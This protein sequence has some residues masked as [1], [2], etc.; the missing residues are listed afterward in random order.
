MEKNQLDLFS[1][2]EIGKTVGSRKPILLM[3]VPALTKWKSQVATHQENI[4]NTQPAQ[5]ISLFNVAPSH[6]SPDTIDPF[7]LQ[8]SPLSF[9][10]LPTDNSGQACLYFITDMSANLLLYVGETSKSNKRWKGVHDCKRYIEKYQDL[11]YR[12]GLKTAVNIAFYWEAPTNKR[13]RQSLELALIQKWKPPFNK[14]NW[15][16][17]GQPFG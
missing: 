12:Y 10:K 11:H 2:S 16:F 14:E 6:V 5:Q 4:R 13:L 7:T 1:K 3:D 8:L 9:Y 17:W 15:K